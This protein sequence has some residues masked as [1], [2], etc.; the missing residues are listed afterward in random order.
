MKA[1]AF[2]GLGL[3]FL[4]LAAISAG[5]RDVQTHFPDVVNTNQVIVELI[6]DGEIPEWMAVIVQTND[7]MDAWRSSQ[8]AAMAKWQSERAAN[9]AARP[10]KMTPPPPNNYFDNASWLPFKTNLLVDL[11]SGDGKRELLFSFKYQG[12]TRSDGW[13]GSGIEV[14]T[15]APVMAITNPKEHVTSQPMIQLQG[16][17]SRQPINIKYD[18]F[19]QN[20]VKTVSGGD[21]LVNDQHFDQALFEFTTNYFTCYDVSLSPGTNTFVVHCADE[22]GNP[23]ST[24]FVIVFT[25]AGDTNPPVFSI[26]SPSPGTV[27]AG[28]SF[29]I[30]GPSD[31]PTA[32]MAGQICAN[33]QTNE[34]NALI[35]RNGYF[36]FEN[37]PLAEGTNYVSFTATDV[38]GNS[39]STNFVVIGSTEVMLTMDAIEPAGQLWQQ[40]IAVV[41]GKVHPANHE[42]WINGIQA[43]VKPDGSWLA[44]KVPVLSS[45]SGGTALF[46]MTSMSP[47]EVAK[48]NAKLNE[49]VSAQASLGTNDMVLNASAPVCGTF[50]L[51]LTGTAGRSFILEASTNLVEW[52]PILTNANPNPT[53]DYTDSNTNGYHCRFFR[54]VPLP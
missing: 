17:V 15:A 35:E 28:T 27:L 11:G 18:L 43:T 38:A 46:N 2:L 48:G 24:R 53:F 29:T 21:A 31:D 9:P 8:Q 36:W 52:S 44:K 14:R 23:A 37:E 33:G 51:H 39:S 3:G 1:K 5:A 4:L 50:Q 10:P 42:V 26:D 6:P 47:D 54:V 12:Q 20:G 40:S 41:T 19:D 32:K 45:P 13:G 25:T 30:R 49:R 22:A 34:I 16:Y 7:P